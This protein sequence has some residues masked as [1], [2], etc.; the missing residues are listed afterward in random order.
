[1]EVDIE[2]E[3]NELELIFLYVEANPLNPPL[4]A[5]DSEPEDVIEVEDTVK[6]ED[7]T[8]PASV[9]EVVSRPLPYSTE[10][11]MIVS[12]ALVKNKG[13]AKDKYYGKLILDL[14]NEV[15]SSVEERADA[16]EN[17]VRKLGNAEEKAKCKKLKKELEESSSSNILLR[18]QKKRVKRD[19]YWTRVQAHE[20]YQEMIRRGVV[21]EERPNEAIHGFLLC[22]DKIMP[23]KSRPLTQVAIKRMITQRVNEALTADRARQANVSGASGSRQGAVELRRWFEKTEMIFGIG[24]C[25]EGLSENIKGEVTSSKSANLSEAVRMAYKLMEKK[26]GNY[27]DNPRYQQNNHKQGHAFSHLIDI[28][29]DKLNVSY[30]VE[31]AGEKVVSTNTVLRGCT[32]NLVNH[33][34]EIDLIPTELAEYDAVIAYGKKVVRIPCGDKTLIVEGDKGPSRLKKSKEKH[35]ED[36]PVICNFPKVRPGDFL[37]LPPPRQVEFKFDLVLRSALVARA[38]YHLSP[39]EMKEMSVQLQELLEKGFIHPSSSP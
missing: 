29:P 8:S 5:F 36:V 34:F 4:P 22:H 31:L 2:E 27:K 3:E 24:E 39:S 35:L 7:E 25:A 32:P 13:K 17:L 14:G 15:R 20:F 9:Y 33:L 10:R 26:V 16:M 6:P 1:M 23:P 19:L 28:N 21:F 30:E 12:H 38:P 18:M 11:M 37:R